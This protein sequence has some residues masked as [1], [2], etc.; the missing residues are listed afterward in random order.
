MIGSVMAMALAGPYTNNLHL[1]H[2]PVKRP[3][4]QVGRYQKGKTNLNFTE[5]KRQ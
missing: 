5:A 1:T 3:F 2:T 4:V